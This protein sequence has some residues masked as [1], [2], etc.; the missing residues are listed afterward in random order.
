[1]K[2][3]MDMKSQRSQQ[4]VAFGLFV[5]SLTA[6]SGCEFE[7]GDWGQARYERS[8]SRQ[9]PL[10]ANG[11]L[12]VAT[13]LGSITVTG[14]DVT[15][16][17]IVAEIVARAP[18]AEEAQQL[19]EQVEI[20]A[21]RVA[22]TLK[23][24]ADQPKLA[25]NRSIGVSY[26]ITA[27]R[28]VN[29]TCDSN[30]GSIRLANI[31]GTAKGRSSSGSMKAESIAGPIDLNTSYGSIRCRS[32][33]GPSVL[34][35][36]SGSITLA[37]LEGSA[38]I[39]TSYGSITCERFSG[40]DLV[41]KTSSGKIAVSDASFL[42]GLAETSYGSVVGTGLQGDAIKLHSSSGS[43]TLTEARAD[44]IDLHTSYGRVEARQITMANLMADSGSGSVDIVCSPETPADLTAEVKS[45]YGGIN[46]TT[47]PGFSGH[48]HLSTGYG[49]IRTALPITLSG[50]VSKKNV[51]GRIGDGAGKIRL[52]SGNGSVE[53]K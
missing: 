50:Q 37:D 3:E 48:V 28:N 39:E 47:P 53:L 49:Q 52:E 34:R 27:P 21:E 51:T 26:T 2:G 7:F 42:T 30:Y 25:H 9:V 1:M 5:L 35:T 22:D 29:V 40:D 12:D 41:L 16:C 15:D 10:A 23:V 32:V 38:K 31:E 17:N 13:Q 4:R 18:T 20:K 6:A 44:V 14:A 46:F 36:S 11:T 33:G 45:S 43:V 8:V 19:A 24:R